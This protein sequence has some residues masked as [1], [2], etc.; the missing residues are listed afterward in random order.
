[1]PNPVERKLVDTT[2]VGLGETIA[3]ASAIALFIFMFLPWYGV[4]SVGGVGVG[5]FGADLSAW[6]AFSFIDILLLAVVAVVVG[7]VVAQAADATPELPQ[8]AATIIAA[9][10]G[11]AVLLILFRLIFAPGVDA[12]AIDVDVDLGRKIGLFLGLLAAAGIAYGGW[13]AMGETAPATRGSGAGPAPG[14]TPDRAEGTEPP[15]GAETKQ[16]SPLGDP[17]SGRP[18]GDPPPPR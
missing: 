9:A 16:P 1:M 4:D 17:E 7:L 5:G 3:A 8:P 15:A 14:A 2:R 12:G 18:G 6:E 10:G 13:R 11:V